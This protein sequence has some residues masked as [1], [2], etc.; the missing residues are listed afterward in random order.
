MSKIEAIKGLTALVTGGSSGLG[1]AVAKLL[2][3]NGANVAVLD[4]P[5]SDGKN[6]VGELGKNA[7]FTAADV[8]NEEQ[9]AKALN[10]VKTN[11]GQLDAVVNCA[12]IAYAFRLYN[13]NKRAMADMDRFKRTLEVNVIGTVNVIRHSAHLMMDKSI[14]KDQERGVII[15]TASIAAF[16]GQIGQTSYSA[17]KGAIHSMTLPLAR[18]FSRES[19]RVC[20]IAPGVFETPMLTSLPQKVQQF[21]SNLTAYPNRLGHG[22]EF[23]ELAQHIILNKYL[24]GETIRL[25]AGLRMPM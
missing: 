4:L 10:D 24:N 19:I 2:H 13:S 21:L 8:S 9:V 23:A 7:I 15:N 22:E 16:D 12:G 17:S 20:T 25:D 5:V 1:R 18:E 6:F 11:F 14:E 3:Q